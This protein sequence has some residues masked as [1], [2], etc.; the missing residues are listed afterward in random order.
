MAFIK[1][2][3]ARE[4]VLI[5]ADVLDKERR[6]WIASRQ[7]ER[8]NNITWVRDNDAPLEQLIPVLKRMRASEDAGKINFLFWAKRE[9]L[10][11]LPTPLEPKPQ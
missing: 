6:A 7:S 10:V 4:V 1:K 9:G 11:D 8:D 2:L 3:S 5:Q